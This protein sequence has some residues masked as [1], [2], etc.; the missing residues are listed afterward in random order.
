ML[1]P[2]H[3]IL[4][5]HL[6]ECYTD[7]GPSDSFWLIA[8]ERLNGILGFVSTN[9]QAIEIQLM[10]KFLSTQQVLQQL[11]CGIVHEGLK[12]ILRS[13]NVVKGS[14]KHEQLSLSQSNADKLRNL[15]HQLEKVV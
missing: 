10:R 9:D 8:F 5:G 2:V 13:A 12:D 4:H 14:L 11:N 15:S 7:Y 1:V 3:L 6:Q